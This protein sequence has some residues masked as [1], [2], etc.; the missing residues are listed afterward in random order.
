MFYECKKFNQPLNKWNV[1][2]VTN[3]EGMFYECKKFNQPLNEW[4]VGNVTNMEG[5]FYE[6]NIFNQPLN[7][8]NVSNVT[9]ME[10]MF[11]RCKSFNQELNDWDVSKVTDMGSM[12]AD[13]IQFNQH[14][15]NWIIH[16]T[17]KHTILHHNGGAL[18]YMFIRSGMDEDKIEDFTNQIDY[19][20]ED[21]DDEEEEP[22]PKYNPLPALK[23]IYKRIPVH[24]HINLEDTNVDH[25]FDQ[26]N[27]S[28]PFIIYSGNS[29]SGNSH[30]WPPSNKIF[31]EC[32]DD[33]PADYQGNTYKNYIKPNGRNI[34]KMNFNGGNLSVIKPTWFKGNVPGTKIFKL[35]KEGTITKFMA[36]ELAI[37]RPF[38]P[39]FSIIG[40]DH[41]NQ[42]GSQ[43]CYRLEEMSV[44]E[45]LLELSKNKKSFKSISK[46]TESIRRSKSLGGNKTNKKR[47]KKFHL[48]RKTRQTIKK[49]LKK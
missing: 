11:C 34:I 43:P 15:N 2:N 16:H 20:D 44:D 6:C 1:S 10:Y 5:M 3:M 39:N 48:I 38:P 28:K 29:F 17:L 47:T 14:L 36:E 8:W 18:H 7:N 31:V 46:S 27:D 41:C 32:K 21:E 35:V 9:D 13:C 45:L 19:H 4:N 22:T 25:F 42:I 26:N 30:R 40:A 37:Q 33:A 49:L 23:N 12:F 24:D